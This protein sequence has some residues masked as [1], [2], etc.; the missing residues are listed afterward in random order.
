[1]EHSIV[2]LVC[3]SGAGKH[4]RSKVRGALGKHRGG[5]EV[6]SLLSRCSMP[7]LSFPALPA[8]RDRQAGVAA[9]VPGGHVCALPRGGGHP[10]H[11][12]RRSPHIAT[13]SSIPLSPPPPPPYPSPNV[14]AFLSQVPRGRPFHQRGSGL[15]LGRRRQ[16]KHGG[17]C[18]LATQLSCARV[19]KLTLLGLCRHPSWMALRR[20]GARSGVAAACATQ[21][22]RPT[23]SGRAG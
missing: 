11:Q 9:G 4:A 21:S 5:M 1:M 3:H 18:M 23:H 6:P 12:V 22:A 15:L 14:L 17:V 13:D 20:A 2:A 19:C 8:G 16:H 7:L 10:G